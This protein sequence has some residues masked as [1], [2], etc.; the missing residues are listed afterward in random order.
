MNGEPPELNGAETLAPDVSPQRRA[1]PVPRAF[2]QLDEKS[3]S[4]HQMSAQIPKNASMSEIVTSIIERGD[5]A[6]LALF[7]W[8]C[9]ASAQAYLTMRELGESTRRFDAFVRELARFNRRF[10]SDS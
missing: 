8:A 4:A 3:D 2:S 1:R 7:L 5:L 10:G 9:A 6:H